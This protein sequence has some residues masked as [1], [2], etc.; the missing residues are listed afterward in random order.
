MLARGAAN[1]TIP[2]KSGSPLIDAVA[3]GD[4]S[5][6]QLVL[7]HSANPQA[8]DAD[9]ITPIMHSVSKNPYDPNLVRL[10][11]EHGAVLDV[12]KNEGLLFQALMAKDQYLVEWLLAHGAEPNIYDDEGHHVLHKMHRRGSE[13]T[14]KLLLDRGADPNCLDSNGNTLLHLEAGTYGELYML[15]LLLACNAYVDVTNLARNTA[16]HEAFNRGDEAL[17]KIQLL[18]DHG[19]D[20]SCP[21]IDGDTPLHLAARTGPQP[22]LTKLLLENEVDVNARDAKGN[23]ALHIAITN[24]ERSKDVVQ[25]LLAHHADPNIRN[26]HGDSPLHLPSSD[27]RKIAAMEEPID[28]DADPG[29]KSVLADLRVAAI[30]NEYDIAQ[31]L[32]SCGADVNA[33]SSEEYTALHIAVMND[34]K[35]VARLLCDHGVDVNAQDSGGRTALHLATL[36]SRSMMMAVLLCNEG[37]DLDVQDNASKRAFDHATAMQD[38]TRIELLSR[39]GANSLAQ[40]FTRVKS[41]RM[42]VMIRCAAI[43]GRNAKRLELP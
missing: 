20:P 24:L 3:T 41:L 29:I 11:L 38:Q 39:F 40:G 16:L 5:L 14:V 43:T 13:C 12:P 10:L 32:L 25:V 31:I 28:G 23:T 42:S 27:R 19:A 35:E 4:L 6:V 21:N 26:F 33:I 37:A 30:S 15:R 34:H 18:I 1:N 8:P 22:D 17:V 7:A 36:E 9:G 2:R